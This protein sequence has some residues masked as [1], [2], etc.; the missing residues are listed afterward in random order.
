MELVEVSAAVTSYMNLFVPEF[1]RIKNNGELLLR[2]LSINTMDDFQV[3]GADY[4]IVAQRLA[5]IFQSIPQL[6]PTSNLR[7][8]GTSGTYGSIYKNTGENTA[9]YKVIDLPAQTDVRLKR[10]MAFLKETFIQH[11]LS[12]DPQYGRHVPKVLGI[13]KDAATGLPSSLTIKMERSNITLKQRL[14]KKIPS[15]Q[16]NYLQPILVELIKLLRNLH[17]KYHFTHRDFKSDNIMYKERVVQFIDFGMSCIHFKAWGKDYNVI[18]N[19][20]YTSR[21]KCMIEQD[22]ALLLLKMQLDFGQYFDDRIK[23]FMADVGMPQFMN[24]LGQIKAQKNAVG[25]EIKLFHVASNRNNTLYYK[26]PGA[27]ANF[28]PDF[29]LGKLGIITGRMNTTRN[30]V[31]RVMPP[32]QLFGQNMTRK[33]NNMGI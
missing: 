15:I 21:S 3:G 33:R 2:L 7:S 30:M 24:T 23:K 12:S 19:V 18:N 22:I 5:D 32:Q 17:M 13:Y 8:T 31:S 26:K 25:P 27:G 20:Y 4:N 28:S 9:I 14:T 16:F 1:Q 29:V 10:M 6:S 11:I